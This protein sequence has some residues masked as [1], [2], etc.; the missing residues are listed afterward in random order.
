MKKFLSN[1]H[2]AVL[3][4]GRNKHSGRRFRFSF[5]TIG[6]VIASTSILLVLVL[7]CFSAPFAWAAGASEGQYGTGGSAAGTVADT[8]GTGGTGGVSAGASSDASGSAGS[9][10]GTPGGSASQTPGGAVDPGTP[11]SETSN[12]NTGVKNQPTNG[13]Y[14]STSS[15]TSTHNKSCSASGLTEEETKECYD[16]HLYCK[17]GDPGVFWAS[18]ADYLAGLLSVNYKL[19]NTGPGTAVDV[20]VT[21]ATATNGVTIA[22]DPLPDFDEIIAGEYVKFTLKWHVPVNVG[23]FVTDLKVCADCKEDNHE[24][25]DGDHKNNDDKKSNNNNNNNLTGD[26]TRG[27]TQPQTQPQSTGLSPSV[28][29]SALPNTGFSLVHAFL[30]LAGIAAVMALLSVPAAKLIRK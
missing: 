8:S 22:T 28:L 3:S 23:S 14:S 18:R 19:E 12:S 1:I 7:V 5:L 24:L 16:L 2:K 9:V 6:R 17:W 26:P 4:G 25:D 30:F 21:S 27:Q 29:P 15:G 13:L 11:K 20:H 10:S